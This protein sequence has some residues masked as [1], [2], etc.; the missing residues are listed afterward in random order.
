[1]HIKVGTRGSK[2]ALAQTNSVIEALKKVAPE[3][4]AEICVIRTSGDIMQDV[5]LA[6]IGGQGVFVKEIEEALLARSIDLAVHSMKDV[7]GETPEGLIFAAVMKRE[8]VRDVLVSRGN[9]KMEFMPKGAKIGT[10]SLRRAA[11]I[12]AMLPDVSIMPLRGNIDT[13]LKKI[14]TENLTGVILAAAG[15]KRMGYLEKITQYLPIEL[16]LP[17]VGQGALG[18]EIRVQDTQLSELCA[19]MNDEQTAAEVAAERAYLRAL[20][21][22]C[23]LPIAAYGLLEGKRLTL[24][25]ILTVPNGSTMIR[26]KVW[27]EIGQA[28]ELG[29]KLAD[30]ILEKGGKRLLDL[31]C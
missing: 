29:K 23:R 13:R 12:K 5:S 6:Q 3:I 20:G 25:G 22:G 9:V 18:L 19:K 10:G 17:A 4:E 2:L 1:M 8:D 31:M 30:L 7:P 15:M 28:E 14:E 16:M 24:E 26:D 21:G 11:Q 27:G